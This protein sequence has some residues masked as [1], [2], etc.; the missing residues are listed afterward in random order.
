MTIALPI[1]VFRVLERVRPATGKS[2]TLTPEPISLEPPY[3]LI[4]NMIE[5]RHLPES[6]RRNLLFYRSVTRR[7]SASRALSASASVE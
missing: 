7:D 6:Q 4:N 3:S 5:V 1:N 2:V